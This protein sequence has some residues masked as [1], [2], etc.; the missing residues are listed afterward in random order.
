MCNHLGYGIKEAVEEE[1]NSVF[2]FFFL[3][4]ERQGDGSA[5]EV[6]LTDI[7]I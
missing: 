6:I 4:E 2:F 5:F 3:D 7:L 1:Y